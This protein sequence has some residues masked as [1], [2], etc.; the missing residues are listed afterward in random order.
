MVDI[1]TLITGPSGSGKELVAR[2]VGQSLY[3]EF[4][5]KGRRFAERRFPPSTC[6]PLR[7]P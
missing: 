1:T 7:R 6:P 4:D 3:T 5:P 2:S